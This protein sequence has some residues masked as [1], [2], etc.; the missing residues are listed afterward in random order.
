MSPP[1]T[2]ENF[3]PDF[4]ARF[5]ALEK[6]LHER[7]L[8]TEHGL[9]KCHQLISTA[10]GYTFEKFVARVDSWLMASATLHLVDKTPPNTSTPASGVEIL[11]FKMTYPYNGPL[12][13]LSALQ[14]AVAYWLEASKS[15][16][17]EDY[18]R[19]LP[20]V[21]IAAHYLGMACAPPSATEHLS[22]KAANAHERSTRLHRAEA[23][24][25]LNALAQGEGAETVDAMAEKIG[26][27]FEEFNRTVIHHWGSDNAVDLLKKWC[28]DKTRA[29]EVRKAWLAVKAKGMEAKS[30]ADPSSRS[31]TRRR[32]I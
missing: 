3:L 6:K 29:P 10:R 24:R 30:K 12:S 2:Q 9:K 5:E 15:F 32:R 31:S 20:A 28:R 1:E 25:L 19:S 8:D 18:A 7:L 13:A 21:I 4:Q 14:L 11:R 17:I 23:V 22:D 27:Q 26:R 16:R